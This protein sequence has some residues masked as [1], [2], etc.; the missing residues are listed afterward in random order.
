MNLL[1]NI[2]AP[3]P[4]CSLDVRRKI[5]AWREEQEGKLK[6]MRSQERYVEDLDF[7]SREG[8]DERN[9]RFV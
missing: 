6:E 3:F 4:M 9:I 7:G 1:L 8:T 5:L 2:E